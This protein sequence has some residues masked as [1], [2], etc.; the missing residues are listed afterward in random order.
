VFGPLL[1]QIDD[2]GELKCTLRVIWLIHQKK[3]YPRF[4]TFSE[5]LSD[6][7]R[8]DARAS[9]GPSGREQ[10]GRAL[11]KAVGRGTLYGVAVQ[12]DGELEQLFALNTEA[13][14]NALDALADSS[15]P[16]ARLPKTEPWEGDASRPNIF[17]MYEDNIGMLSPMIADELKEAEELYPSAWIEEAF[18]EAVSQN[19]RTWRYIARILERWE[20]EGRT[21]GEPGR[22]LKKTDYY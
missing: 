7:T 6:R 12:R 22:H 11:E 5:L 13:D 3:G 14:R 15:A 10:V 16:A 9:S 4:L 18:R 17:A 8:V 20:R 1:E 21:D 2:L 19:K